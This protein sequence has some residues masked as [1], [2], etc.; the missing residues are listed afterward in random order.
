LT[1]QTILNISV[2]VLPVVLAIT[3]HEA[4]HGYAAMRLGDDTAERAG[5]ISINPIR[6]ISLFGT[7]ILPA[8]LLWAS[9]GAFA[10]G[11]AKPV[12]VNFTRLNNPRR[13]MV[14]V[15][16]AGPGANM[17]MAAIAS[18]LFAVTSPDGGVA[19]EWLRANFAAATAINVLLAVFNMLPIPPLDGGR[20]AV[21]LLPNFIAFPLARLERV[22]I[23]IVLGAIFLL[24]NLGF[25][26]FR[27]VILP[28]VSVLLSLIG[29]PSLFELPDVVTF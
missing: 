15:A 25:D 27:S 7:I 5:R 24:P 13:D 28:V 20:V 16:A 21:G 18:V 9:K 19:M 10:F 11:M 12:P 29:A 3:L 8:V 4:A 23:F 22:G 2:W 6:H 1:L 17:A 14:W 26:F